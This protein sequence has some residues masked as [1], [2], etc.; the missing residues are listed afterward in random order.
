MKVD[1]RA[2]NIHAGKLTQKNC[3]L[4]INSLFLLFS[5]SL[6]FYLIKSVVQDF[7]DLR[8]NLSAV[9]AVKMKKTTADNKPYLMDGG[10]K[11]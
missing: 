5:L 4:Q 10:S 6:S 3:I 2:T 1:L 11:N 7:H 8:S 9:K